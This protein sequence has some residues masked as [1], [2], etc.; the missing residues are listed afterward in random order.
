[1]VESKPK[2]SFNNSVV[3]FKFIQSDSDVKNSSSNFQ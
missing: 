3:I 1:M 2:S